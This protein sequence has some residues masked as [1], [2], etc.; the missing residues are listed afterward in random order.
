MSIPKIEMP[1]LEIPNSNMITGKIKEGI[2][3]L[4]IVAR[5]Q[6]LEKWKKQIADP[7]IQE[8]LTNLNIMYKDVKNIYQDTLNIYNKLKGAAN[9]FANEV[10]SMA[11]PVQTTINNI[12]WLYTDYKEIRASLSGWIPNVIG[13]LV[14]TIEAVHHTVGMSIGIRDVFNGFKN[15]LFPALSNSL[16]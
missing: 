1:K 6:N 7:Q 15:R 11:K 4:D 2:S 8:N 12:G 14:H 13:A 5:L 9:N 3:Q 16:K 10:K